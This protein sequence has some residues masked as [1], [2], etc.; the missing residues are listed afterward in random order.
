MFVCYISNFISHLLCDQTPAIRCSLVRYGI[1]K[2]A[3][4]VL[5]VIIANVPAR[6]NFLLVGHGHFCVRKNENG[7]NK[8]CEEKI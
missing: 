6:L 7:D 5:L 2:F 3:K 1:W 8:W 4:K